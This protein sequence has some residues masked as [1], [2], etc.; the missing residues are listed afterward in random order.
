MPSSTTARPNGTSGR[1][2]LKERA[3]SEIKQRIVDGVFAPSTFLSERQLAGQ[4]DMSKTPVRAALDRLE[5]EGLVSTSPQQGVIVRDLS[6]H[7][8]ADLYEMRAALETYTVRAI[9]GRVTEEQKRLVQENLRAQQKACPKGDV[10]TVVTLD[11]A[12]HMLLCS[13]LGN[14][15]MVRVMSQLRDKVFRVISR[16]FQVNPPRIHQSFV[17]HKAIADAIF[18]GQADV[19]AQRIV[20]HLER[21]KKHLLSP[22]GN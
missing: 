16:V 8:I 4:L 17:E 6:V 9:A 20:E 7:E 5:Q 18:A 10:Q 11:A 12:F 21:G 13:F 15:E 1:S 14:D 19:A 2:L 22:R 3:Y